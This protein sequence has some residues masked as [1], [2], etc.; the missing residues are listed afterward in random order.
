MINYQGAEIVGQNWFETCLPKQD[1]VES[2][3]RFKARVQN[4][5]DLEVPSESRVLTKQGDFRIV[6]WRDTSLYDPNKNLIGILYLG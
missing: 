4:K 2:Q 5:V 6:E 1:G 3:N